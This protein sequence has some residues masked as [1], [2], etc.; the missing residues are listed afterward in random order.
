MHPLILTS[1][2]ALVLPAFLPTAQAAVW[3]TNAPMSSARHDPTA[4]LLPNGKVLVAGGYNGSSYTGSAEL[5]DPATGNWTATGSMIT[6]RYRHTATLLLN[7]KVLV[8]GGYGNGAA[9]LGNAELY[10]PATGIWTPAGSFSPGRN[11]HV[12][13]LLPNGKVLV[14]GGLVDT[15]GNHT[16]SAALY[17][18][19]TGTW[20]NTGS[21]SVPRGWPTATLLPNGKVL[22]A[23]GA[24][25]VS[26][27]IAYHYT[28]ELY[29]PAT[30]NWTLTGSMSQS[31]NL[32]TATLLPNG[33]VRVAGGETTNTSIAT[34]ELYN[35]ATGSW[36]NTG[37]LGAVRESHQ[38]VLLPNGKVVAAAGDNLATVSWLTSTEMYDPARGTW[39]P[40]GTLN[41]PRDHFVMT[42]LTNGN[43]LAVGGRSPGI[44]AIASSET[45]TSSN[46]T[47]AAFNLSKPTKLPGGQF[48]FTF[49]N[50]P[51]VSFLAFATANVSTPFSNS[52]AVSGPI[53]ISPGQ[54]QFNDPRAT[55]SPQ[56]FCRIR[57]PQ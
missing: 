16:T 4:T 9:F 41:T 34:A 30:G 13:T 46:I 42:L 57:S 28:A 19:A 47:V 56:R 12:A 1:L 10:D 52:T 14:A 31:R 53:E 27:G 32:H 8:A 54:Y 39:I 20:A 40:A 22:V 55:N 17:D 50:T 48:Q 44:T 36:T 26:G 3:I 5:Y 18:P 37:S 15:T 51:D 7:G 2:A 33:L 25:A 29:D 23:G 38:A 43:V 45:Y 21:L 11:R 6:G 49:T 24:S 35:P